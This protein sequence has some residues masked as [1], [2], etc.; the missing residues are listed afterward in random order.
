VTISELCPEEVWPDPPNPAGTGPTYPENLAKWTDYVRSQ[1]GFTVHNHQL[2]HGV[3]EVTTSHDD[4]FGYSC[5]ATCRR[6]VGASS[7]ALPSTARETSTRRYRL[8]RSDWSP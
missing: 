7:T 3:I 6:L 2:G 5:R 4:I 8:G 1:D